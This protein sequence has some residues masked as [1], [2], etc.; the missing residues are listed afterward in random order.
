MQRS[1]I[2]E[3]AAGRRSTHLTKEKPLVR[4][5]SLLGKYILLGNLSRP[6][7]TYSV[8][9]IAGRTGDRRFPRQMR[10]DRPNNPSVR[11]EKWSITARPTR[12]SPDC[13]R[14]SIA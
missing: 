13:R 11:N 14:S 12:L 10:A 6:Y 3:M 5:F 4:A 8:S 2:A 9:Y 7:W 1:R